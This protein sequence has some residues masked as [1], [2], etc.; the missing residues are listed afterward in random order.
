[1]QAVPSLFGWKFE[2]HWGADFDINVDS[3]VS[4]FSFHKILFEIKADY[5]VVF[6]SVW[7][8]NKM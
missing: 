2:N 3:G 8:A 5:H 1:M 6:L 7:Q 4:A